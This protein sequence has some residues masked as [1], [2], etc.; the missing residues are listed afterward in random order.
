MIKKTLFGIALLIGVPVPGHAGAV[1]I[2]VVGPDGGKSTFDRSEIAS[3]ALRADEVEF[4][5]KDGNSSVFQKQDI[6]QILL[7]DDTS[8]VSLVTDGGHTVTVKA[9][10]GSIS[11]EGAAEGRGWILTDM[12]GLNLM[13]GACTGVNDTVDISSLS[14][15]IYFFTV[16]GKTI[17][18]IK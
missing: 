1:K 14:E 2:S 13:S 15:G 17:K 10:K 11:I 7:T 12:S 18:F 8:G 4:I 6:S 16:S 5:G 9:T 3:I